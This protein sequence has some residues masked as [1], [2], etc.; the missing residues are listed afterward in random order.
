[1]CEI[2]SLYSKPHI[3]S[4]IHLLGDR[5]YKAFM[6]VT[7]L[8][9][10][11]FMF[12]SQWKQALGSGVVIWR[13][14]VNATFGIKRSHSRWHLI[15]TIH[16]RGWHHLPSLLLNLG[17][18]SKFNNPIS[19]RP[20]TMFFFCIIGLPCEKHLTIKHYY[21]MW[22]LFTNPCSLDSE[23]IAFSLVPIHYNQ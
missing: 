5:R 2:S 10:L 15:Q 21:K 19:L 12:C 7:Y 18:F 9:Y 4:H 16:W 6:H 14:H 23:F 8:G 13:P 11:A 22:V 3:K 1:M 20:F 17:E